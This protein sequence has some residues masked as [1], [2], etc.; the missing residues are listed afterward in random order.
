MYDGLCRPLEWIL[1]EPLIEPYVKGFYVDDQHYSMPLGKL[2]NCTLN[3]FINADTQYM[4]LLKDG[5]FDNIDQLVAI[6]VREDIESPDEIQR[7]GDTRV[8]LA[9]LG[10]NPRIEKL[11]KLSMAEKFYVAYFF[12]CCKQLIFNEYGEAFE[13]GD[14]QYVSK[15]KPVSETY[16]DDILTDVAESQVF[17]SYK[18]ILEINVHVF[19]QWLKKISLKEQERAK[20]EFQNIIAE[21]HNKMAK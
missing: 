17:G 14:K 13:K 1:T 11:T 7:R 19:F 16:W 15:P 3:E 21:H 20:K 5:G 18:E 4:K 10:I 6:L 9:R 2:A 12:S 8:P